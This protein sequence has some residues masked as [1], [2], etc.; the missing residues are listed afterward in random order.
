MDAEDDR[1]FIL[2]TDVRRRCLLRQ[3]EIRSGTHWR[4]R[5]CG[6]HNGIAPLVTK[7]EDEDNATL[8]DLTEARIIYCRARLTDWRCELG[9]QLSRRRTFAVFE[10]IHE[11]LQ[12]VFRHAKGTAFLTPERDSGLDLA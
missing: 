5:G 11:L 7:V 3:H 2:D 12:L 10:S 4:C 9:R 1:R 6:T 8:R